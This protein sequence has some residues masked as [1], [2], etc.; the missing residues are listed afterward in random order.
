MAGGKAKLARGLLLQ[1][2]CCEGG[3]RI[4]GERLGFDAFNLELP[5][6]YVSLGGERIAFLAQ[7]QLLYLLPLPADQACSEVLAILLHF[8]GYRPIFLGLE[9]FD[10]AFALDDKA[11]SHRLHPPSRFCSGKFAP[12]NRRQGEAN[13]IIERTAS[14]KGHAK[15]V[16]KECVST[17]RSRGS[18]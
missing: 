2:G 12:K 5:R 9:G 3:R 11:E 18:P 15:K 4:A 10:F 13:T 17:G 16:G 7:R 14:A 1:R 8:G 6:L